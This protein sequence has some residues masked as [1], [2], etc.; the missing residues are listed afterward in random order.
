MDELGRYGHG[1]ESN[2]F[3]LSFNCIPGFPAELRAQD[4]LFYGQS[5]IIDSLM[6]V[7]SLNMILG[8]IENKVN[9]LIYTA[10]RH[11]GSIG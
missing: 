4:N 6:Q 10:L 1:H 8:H 9:I 7:Q 3:A 11:S 2:C 5:E